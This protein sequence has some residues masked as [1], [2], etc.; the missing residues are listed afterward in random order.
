MDL[1]EIIQLRDTKQKQLTVLLQNKGKIDEEYGSL[2]L[3]MA[4]LE[5]K[6]RKLMNSRTKAG[7]LISVIRVEIENLKDLYFSTKP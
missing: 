3:E 7:A 4:Q 1:E 5:V 6:K 2:A